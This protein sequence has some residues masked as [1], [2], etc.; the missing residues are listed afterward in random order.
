MGGWN[1]N[2]HYHGIVLEAV[3]PGCRRALDVGCGAG[4]LTGKLAGGCEVVG[5]DV[6]RRELHDSIRFIE[7]DVMSYPFAKGSFDLITVVATLHHLP[8]RPALARFRELLRLGGV[9]VVIGLYRVET[10]QDYA[11][12]AVAIPISRIFRCLR[13]Q[14]EVNARLQEPKETLREI[15]AACDGVLPGGVFRRLL[16]LRY[17]FVWRKGLQANASSGN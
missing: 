10:F 3:P 5:I 13:G 2:I 15:R 14:P 1:H 16:F 7:G 11:L 17:S 4:L 8:L 6:D 9:L 12:A